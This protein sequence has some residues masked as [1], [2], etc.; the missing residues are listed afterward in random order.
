MK[1]TRTISGLAA[2]AATLAF[3]PFASAQTN[4]GFE[5]DKAV[6]GM[7]E[8][9]N[10]AYDAADRCE[11]KATSNA[12]INGTSTEFELDPPNIMRATAQAGWVPGSYTAE[13]TCGGEKVVRPFKV[14]QTDE[15]TFFLDKNQVEAGG[16]VTV[17]KTAKSGCGDAA[18][19][20]GFVSRIELKQQA[21]G[22]WSGT[23]KAVDTPGTYQVAMLCFG[24]HT[25]RQLTVLPKT[26][27]P[28]QPPTTVTEKPRPKAPIVK[29]KGAPQTGG[30]GTA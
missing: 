8:T 21:D 22:T 1:N 25:Y 18:N 24:T 26:P 27:E 12:F 14:V 10:L 13:M 15:L 16:E 28:T 7:A 20:P 9:I 3:A 30:G 29:P 19:S 2:I 6:Y 23:A 11:G 17:R 5:L 4:A